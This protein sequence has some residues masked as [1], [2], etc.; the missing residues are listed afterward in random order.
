MLD[1]AGAQQFM[2]ALINRDR[3]QAGLP[4][5][6]FDEAASRSGLR[7]ARD[8]S[9]NGFTGHV[10]T[11]GSVPEQRYTESGGVDFVQENAA[12]LFDAK[13]RKLDPNAR[14][15]RAKLAALHK[16]FMDEVPPNDGH[17]RN[18]L[19]A[20]HN[21][22][23]I[24][25][26]QAANLDQPCLTEEFVDHYGTYEPLPQHAKPKSRVRVAGTVLAPLAFGGVGIARTP[27]PEPKR[28]EELNGRGG[29]RIPPADTMYYPAGFKTPKEVKLDGNRF[30]IDLELGQTARP[31]QYEVSVWAKTAGSNRLF[32]VSLRTITVR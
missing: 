24:G 31:G 2:V 18:I 29:Y 12:C 9:A 17:R 30:S 23:G 14:F 28:R 32:M 16:M 22:V 15:D 25:V 21:R 6:V 13:E 27:L 5:V 8:M 7:H 1:L 20:V 4:P 26:A 10:G 19:T 3:A 11:D